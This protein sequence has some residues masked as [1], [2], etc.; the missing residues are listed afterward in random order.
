MLI[1]RE[2]RPGIASETTHTRIGENK[3]RPTTCA[4]APN[5][6]AAVEMNCRRLTRITRGHCPGAGDS[7]L[8]RRIVAYR[9]A[10]KH[11]PK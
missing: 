6:R 11:A 10:G 4:A 8:G 3:A 7:R 1:G 9:G 5:A 2:A